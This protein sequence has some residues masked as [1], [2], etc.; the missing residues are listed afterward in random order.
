MDL[1]YL[2]RLVRCWERNAVKEIATAARENEMK[3]AAFF[4]KK[5]ASIVLATIY[6]N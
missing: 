1:K 2:H 6:V 5:E 4:S 3:S